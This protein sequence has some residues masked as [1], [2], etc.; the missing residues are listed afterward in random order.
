METLTT[1]CA[2]LSGIG[3]QRA[4]A[5]AKLGIVELQDVLSHF[6]RTY[7]DRSRTVE[8]REAFTMDGESV[9]VR[10][11]VVDVPIY[12]FV[13]KGLDWVKFNIFDETATLKITFFN[14]PY[15]KEKFIRGQEYAFFGKIKRDGSWLNLDNPEFERI[16][17]IV[18][19]YRLTHGISQNLLASLAEKA[20]K[21]VDEI[22][23]IIPNE[24]RS[25]YELLDVQT[26][27]TNIHFPEDIELTAEARRR[28][29]FEEFFVLSLALKELRRRNDNASA[30]VL[31]S[32]TDYE[33][34][35]Q[36]L[37]FAPTNAQK[38]AISD[39]DTDLSSGKSMN[40]LIQ[41]DVGSG[42]TLVA[43]AIIWKVCTS[44]YQAAFMAPTEILAEQH[45]KTLTKFLEPFGIRIALLTGSMSAKEKTTAKSL[46][47]SGIVRLIVG[48]HALISKDTEFFK[49]ALAITDEQHR[50]GVAQRS[51]LMA[52][53]AER[54][55]ILVMSATPIPRTLAIMMYGDLDVSIIDELPPGRQEIRT[56]LVSERARSRV[57]KFAEKLVNE[58]HQVYIVCPAI[59]DN[60]AIEMK[61]VESYAERLKREFPKLRV[62]ILHGRLKP[63]EKDE[64]MSEFSK[65]EIDI[66]V[67]TT[68]I[69]VG[70][71]VPNAALMI[72]ENAERFGLSQ[73]HQLR[74]RVGRGSA[75]SYCVLLIG[76]G[77]E[78]TLERLKSFCS[79]TDGFKIAETD[80]N[81]RGPGDFFGSRQHGLP[82]MK[83]AYLQG[84][85]D[86]LKQAQE[87]ASAVDVEQN[88]PLDA[89][90]A[91]LL[92]KAVRNIKPLVEVRGQRSEMGSCIIPQSEMQLPISDF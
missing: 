60:P 42:K 4:A 12:R 34:F 16:G 14:R 17:C 7:E 18:P 6:P 11:T 81:I 5:L 70:M 79:T 48:T 86:T 46:I 77:D 56:S 44:G 30:Y 54:P 85:L 19:I 45:Y 59:E 69:E 22:P 24:V 63:I 73:L 43:A 3:T 21:L 38:K 78:T 92:E 50:F 1:K 84:N 61:S 20:V 72:I 28:F 83:I 13:R 76:G 33:T 23:E 89:R 2:D 88:T 55:H 62:S 10:G 51:A 67:S 65:G 25:K 40:R 52:K 9:C 41:G 8:L 47:K 64:I 80:L 74:G 32:A 90:I 57:H 26:A 91:A 15:L 35:Y 49:L 87:A 36:T 82:E 75:Q 66:L 58:G 71:D 31:S 53:A 68:V 39:A 37:P 29:A 27:Y